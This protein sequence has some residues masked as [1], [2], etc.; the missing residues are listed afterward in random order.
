[1][2]H[3]GSCL[4]GGIEF[5]INTELAPIQVCHC[6]Q[7]RK[8]QGGPFA[9][10]IPVPTVAFVLITGTE[11]LKQYESS[12]GKYRHFCQICGSPVFSSRQ[13]LPDVIR[14]RAGLINE[15]LGTKL[16]F[17]AHVDSQC[18]WWPINDDIPQFPGAFIQNHT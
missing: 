7:C 2:A 6:S 13:S 10:N 15:E 1:M 5:S 11:L 18:E 16:A 8:A 4:C 14:V 17:H 9:T 3:T 12:E